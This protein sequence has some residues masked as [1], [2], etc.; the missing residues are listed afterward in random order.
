MFERMLTIIGIVSQYIMDDIDIF[1]QELE[2]VAH[3]HF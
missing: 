1:D 2:I 3:E